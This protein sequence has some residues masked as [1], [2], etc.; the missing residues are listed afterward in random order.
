[1]MGLTVDIQLYLLLPGFGKYDY[2]KA[3]T[4]EY[5]GADACGLLVVSEQP[6]SRDGTRCPDCACNQEDDLLCKAIHVRVPFS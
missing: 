6:Y 5:H 1:M 3:D 4:R 2:E